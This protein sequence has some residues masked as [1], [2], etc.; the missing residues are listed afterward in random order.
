[1]IEINAGSIEEQ[2]IRL[3]QKIYPITVDEIKN[4]LNLSRDRVIRVLK[5]LQIKGIVNLEPL[6]DKIYVRLLRHDFNFIRKKRQKK[7]IKHHT[8]RKNQESSE[9]NEMMY[10]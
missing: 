10:S 4:R 8:G 1:M 9:N 2:I 3:L 7:F 5:K 6:P